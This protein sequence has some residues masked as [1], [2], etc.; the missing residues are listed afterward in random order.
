[1]KVSLSG[2]FLAWLFDR[3]CLCPIC[4]MPSNDGHTHKDGE[5]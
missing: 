5:S 1:M 2:R 4:K 3:L